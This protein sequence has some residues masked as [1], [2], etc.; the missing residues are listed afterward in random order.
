MLRLCQNGV[1]DIE[2]ISADRLY[3]ME[4]QLRPN[5][6]SAVFIPGECI[7]DPLTLPYILYMQSQLLGGRTQMNLD[8]TEGQYD[9]ENQ[10]WSLNKGQLKGR[11]IINCA[12]LFGD[13]VEQIRLNMNEEQSH[14]PS[15][16]IQPRLGQFAVYAQTKDQ[17]LIRSIMLP[18]PTKFTKG[19]IIYPNLFNQIIVGPTAETQEDRRRSPVRSEINALL[20]KKIIDLFPTF[21]SSDY[22]YMGSYTGIRPAT[23]YSDYQIHI[24]EEVQWICCGGIRSTGLTSSLAIGEYVCDQLTTLAKIHAKLQ[25]QGYSE[26]RYNQSIQELQSMF[27]LKK[28]GLQVKL[29]PAQSD[30][31]LDTTGDILFDQQIPRNHLQIVCGDDSL[32]ISHSLTRLAWT[33]NF[34]S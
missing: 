27:L 9:R 20:H 6:L 10:Y 2:E 7:V 32:A 34:N 17:P 24:Y 30:L 29:V 15:F 8:V 16:H 4:P 33:T 5:A 21:L 31:Q 19:I 1:Y 25:C 13:Q 23:E 18:I 12:G 28:Q 26:E 3:Q 22:R 11:V 14:Q